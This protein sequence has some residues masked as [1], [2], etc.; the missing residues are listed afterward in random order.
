MQKNYRNLFAVTD[1]IVGELK[2]P[3]YKEG[4]FENLSNAIPINEYEESDDVECFENGLP[5]IVRI[6]GDL[7]QIYGRDHLVKKVYL[8]NENGTYDLIVKKVEE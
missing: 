8:Y 7:L 1:I 5:V 4:N 2:A 3:T 6:V